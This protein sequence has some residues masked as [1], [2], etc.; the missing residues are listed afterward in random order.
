MRG[1]PFVVVWR[2]D[3]TTEAL[4]ETYRAERDGL[5][6]SRLQALWLLRDGRSLGEVTA[7]LGVHYRSLQR[8]VAWYREGGLALVRARRSGGVGHPAFL[9]AAAQAEVARAVATGRFRTAAQIRAWIAQTYQ[10]AYT[11]GGI[12]TLV[13]RLGCR[14]K[15]PRP[16]HSKTD[17]AQQEAWKR[18]A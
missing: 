10:V 3:D 4:K 8:W 15:V 13:E 7:A 2:K 17:L 9:S 16:I 14:L 6:R 12:Y 18:G 5:I 11:I 1:R